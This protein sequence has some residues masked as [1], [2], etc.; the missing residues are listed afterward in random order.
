MLASPSTPRS[1]VLLELKSALF[2]AVTHRLGLPVEPA[3]EALARIVKKE[4]SLDDRAYSAFK[5]VLATMQRTEAS[6]VAGRPAA[7]SDAA[8]TRAA[9]LVAAIL[10][11]LGI[12][13]RS[14]IPGATVAAAS[15]VDA[16]ARARPAAPAAHNGDSA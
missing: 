1:L 15:A 7:I 10:E 5:E 6:V 11:T 16:V 13:P 8:L 9:E 4:A 14:P 2:E 3:P 12:D